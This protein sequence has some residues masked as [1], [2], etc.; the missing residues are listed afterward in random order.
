M[1]FFLSCPTVPSSFWAGLSEGLTNGDITLSIFPLSLSVFLS[2]F[3]AGGKLGKGTPFSSF[4]IFCPLFFNTSLPSSFLITSS[5]SFF[6]DSITFSLSSF[7]SVNEGFGVNISITFGGSASI[8][9]V[10]NLVSGETGG[11]EKSGLSCFKSPAI[12]WSGTIVPGTLSSLFVISEFDFSCVDAT[13]SMPV[14]SFAVF[15]NPI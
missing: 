9:S 8:L 3:L 13:L 15:I 12:I 1:L 5:D 7:G 4:K 6:S 14:F 2:S 11:A 10:E